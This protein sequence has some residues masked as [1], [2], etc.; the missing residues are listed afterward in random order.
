[1]ESISAEGLKELLDEGRDV[2]LIDVREPWEYEICR[3]VGSR[4]IP[5]SEIPGELDTLEQDKDT[6][7]ICHHGMR[8]LQVAGFLDHAGFRRVINLDGGIDAWATRIETTMAQY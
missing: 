8:S 3:I 5:M 2:A 1:M 7:V 4:N 6:V